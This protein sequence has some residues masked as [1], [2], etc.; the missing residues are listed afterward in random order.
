MMGSHIDTVGNGGHLDGCYGVIAA[1]EVI[2]TFIDQDK[3]PQYDLTVAIFTNEEGVRF[4]PDM[5]GSLVYVGG[6]SVKNAHDTISQSVRLVMCR[7]YHG[8][9][10]FL[11]DNPTTRVPHRWK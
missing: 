3:A 2:A 4:Q 6:M 5:M 11:R 7:A 10:W 9:M 1:L 8:R